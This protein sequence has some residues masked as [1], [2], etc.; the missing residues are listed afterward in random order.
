MKEKT[1]QTTEKDLKQMEEAVD[2][3]T[4]AEKIIIPLLD[5]TGIK[6]DFAR[7]YYPTTRY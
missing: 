4:I 3:Q 2:M 1:S 5:A 7:G 6:G